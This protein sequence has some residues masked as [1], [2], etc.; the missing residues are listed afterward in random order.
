MSQFTNFCLSSH[1]L[2]AKLFFLASIVVIADALF[3]SPKYTF[4]KGRTYQLTS[5]TPFRLNNQQHSPARR[6]DKI[7]F[8]AQ[9]RVSVACV[10]TAIIMAPQALLMLGLCEER[11]GWENTS[12][13]NSVQGSPPKR[14]SPGCVNAAGKAKKKW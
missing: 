11:S 1:N 6:V 9:D 3:A 10:M 2:Q 7:I 5:N 12:H 13:L 14:W 8:Q 4:R